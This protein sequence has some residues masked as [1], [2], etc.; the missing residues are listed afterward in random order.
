[1]ACVYD[2]GSAGKTESQAE[3]DLKALFTQ[4]AYPPLHQGVGVRLEP[5]PLIQED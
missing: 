5:A 3:L 2:G 4:H 1:M